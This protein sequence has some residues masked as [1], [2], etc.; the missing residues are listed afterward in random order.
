MISFKAHAMSAFRGV[1]TQTDS[2]TPNSP[3]ASS[4]RHIP[5]VGRWRLSSD[6]DTDDEESKPSTSGVGQPSWST[7]DE[8]RQLLCTDDDSSE[9]ENSDNTRD[10]NV[11]AITN[12]QLKYYLTQFKSLQSNLHGV[13]S[14]AQATHFFGRSYLP[15]KDLRKVWQLSDFTKD[16]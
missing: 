12:E 7:Y 10:K 13:I 6:Q 16:D 3:A 14:G 11:W 2:T 8:N 4:L 15:L 1:E 5:Y 9:E